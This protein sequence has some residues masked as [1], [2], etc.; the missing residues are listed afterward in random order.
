MVALTSGKDFVNGMAI[1]FVLIIGSAK[2]LSKIFSKY[3]SATNYLRNSEQRQPLL[4][5]PPAKHD[6]TNNFLTGFC[7]PSV[8]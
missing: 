6:L 1:L 4:V 2:T 8:R 5:Q 7:H 3:L